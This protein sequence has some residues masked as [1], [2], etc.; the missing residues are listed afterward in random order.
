MSCSKNC[1]ISIK[2]GNHFCHTNKVIA[3]CNNQTINKAIRARAQAYTFAQEK[4]RKKERN[5]NI[6]K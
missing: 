1:A 4:L 3:S 6:E 5:E 2:N